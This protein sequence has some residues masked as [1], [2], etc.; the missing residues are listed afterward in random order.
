M[1]RAVAALASLVLAATAA[2]AASAPREFRIDASH[3]RVAFSIPF[4]RSHVQGQFEDVKGY[5]SVDP[6]ASGRSGITVRIAT[7][8]L[9]TGSAHRDEHLRSSDFFDAAR[10]PDITFKSDDVRRA[11]GTFV[12]TGT[13]GMHGVTK[14]VRLEVIETYPATP[15]PHGSTILEFR[16][17]TRLARK[18][19]GILGGSKFNDWFDELRSRTMGDSVDVELEIAGFAIDY[20]RTKAND[21]ALTRVEQR[22]IGPLLTRMRGLAAHPDSL[23]GWPWDIEQLG[24][25]LVS[26]GRAGEGL[27]VLR[28]FAEVLPD[29]A[30]GFA[31]LARGYELA[32]KPDSARIAA[33][34]AAR[35]DPAGPRASEILRRV[36]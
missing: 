32:G 13:L 21:A 24:F 1:T 8:S 30:T 35:S 17:T 23:A 3:S 12:L 27:A 26:R 19:F 9:H 2:A 25:A 15:D 16:G 20:D 7:K 6:E 29:T 5:L 36:R 14:P 10:Y 18:D 33:R 34:Q 31:M 4:L 11:N 28:T 22:G